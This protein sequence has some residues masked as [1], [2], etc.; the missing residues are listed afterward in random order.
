M[1]RGV[2][3]L[4]TLAA[5]LLPLP[6]SGTRRETWVEVRTPNFI[7]V[8][9]TSEKDARKF[10]IEFEQIRQVF[11]AS[12]PFASKHPSP[13]I[14]I[15]AAKDE[16]AYRELYPEFWQKGH[17][18]PAGMFEHSFNMSVITVQMDARSQFRDASPFEALYHEYYHSLTVPFYPG[19]PLWL[20]EGLADFYGN[21]VISG[22][23]TTIGRPDPD[24]ILELRER[25][26]IP[27]ATLLDV[28]HSSPYYTEEGK[29][30]IFY[31][32]SW[33]FT[34][35]L[36][37]GDRE[38]HRALLTKYLDL[39]SNGASQ[40]D[41]AVQAFGDLKKMQEILARYV[42]E[43]SFTAIQMK[44]PPGTPDAD[45][46][47]RTLSDAEAE[48]YRAYV[49]L[50]RG[51]FDE[52][53]PMLEDAVNSN[54][55]L[56]PAHQYLGIIDFFTGKHEEAL[57]ELSKAIALDPSSGMPRYLRA[58]LELRAG[59]EDDTSQTADDLRAAIKAMPNF[60]PPYSMLAVVLAR[61]SAT[62]DEALQMAQKA[63][64]MEPASAEFQL[65]LGQVYASLG[66]FSDAHMA[67]LRALEW[68]R[69]PDGKAR[70]KA[71]LDEEKAAQLA[72]ASERATTVDVLNSLPPA[73]SG[74]RKYVT[75]T[76]IASNV[77]C[78]DGLK[79]DVTNPQGV[80]HLRIAPGTSVSISIPG[81][82]HG[83][84]SP[85]QTLSGKT[86]NATYLAESGNELS[87]D[88]ESLSVVEPDSAGAAADPLRGH[89]PPDANV[90][91]LEGTADKVSCSGNEMYLTLSTP[92][93]FVPLHAKD[94][95]QVVFNAD[96][97]SQRGDFSPCTGLKGLKL[98]VGFISKPQKNS[99]GEIQGIVIEK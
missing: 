7:V 57:A 63:V 71:F 4:L 98:R 67:G 76:G 59:P 42:S 33:A 51:R 32:E 6:L 16:T 24:H 25:Q 30:S 17:S 49:F 39:L 34:H 53:R 97:P 62:R 36:M 43:Y 64:S 86:V 45:I 69:T 58:Y 70:A 95:R 12:L 89:A 44:T 72:A 80:S 56:A 23:S 46:K 81:D 21:T 65:N 84:A 83:S 77:N 48:T 27:L 90:L 91:R 92:A 10:A 18:H 11:R 85:C 87:G 15:V 2:I 40:D 79:L 29:T 93:A 61:D 28:T 22:D 68:A 9:D 14:T 37:I 19:L 26:L 47:V 94:L 99:A 82:T 96:S 52:A 74:P 5:F 75:V 38:A 78:T 41:A 31:A 13:V 1:T 3:A 60:A 66:K 35:Y 8:S 55:G 88:L 73:T 54:P 50:V 20:T